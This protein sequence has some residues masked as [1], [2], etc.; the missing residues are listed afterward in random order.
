VLACV[1]TVSAMASLLLGS[2][3]ELDPASETFAAYFERLEQFFVANGIGQ[4]PADATAA[5]SQQE[6]GCR[7]D[8]RNRKENLWH[9]S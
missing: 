8:L 3:G 5:R 4:C 6:K 1:F 7:N 2:V 9:S